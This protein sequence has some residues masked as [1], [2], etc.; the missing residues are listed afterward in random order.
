LGGCL[1]A[2]RPVV[3]PRASPIPPALRAPE[4][5]RRTQAA[6]RTGLGPWRTTTLRAPS[7]PTDPTGEEGE[8]L[9]RR[10]RARSVWATRSH[11]IPALPRTTARGRTT[12]APSPPR[13]GLRQAEVRPREGVRRMLD[14][15]AKRPHGGEAGLEAAAVVADGLPRLVLVDVGELTPAVT[16]RMSNDG[17]RAMVQ[18]RV[19]IL[20]P[21]VNVVA[22]GVN[23]LGPGEEDRDHGFLRITSTRAPKAAQSARIASLLSTWARTSERV[24][25]CW[26]V[27]VTASPT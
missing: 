15:A 3:T 20:V 25:A 13:D 11:R 6:S 8:A 24:R 14:D 21:E 17:P 4:A 27:G 16:G 5:P 2:P 23:P 18:A 12:S 10:S 26:S 22:A 7:P 9:A 1:H 19:P